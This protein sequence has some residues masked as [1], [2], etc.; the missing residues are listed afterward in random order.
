MNCEL[1]SCP[2]L[3][4]IFSHLSRRALVVHL[5]SCDSLH[6]RLVHYFTVTVMRKNFQTCWRTPTVSPGMHIIVTRSAIISDLWHSEVKEYFVSIFDLL[7]QTYLQ[8]EA[9]LLGLYRSLRAEPDSLIYS[10][11]H[12]CNFNPLNP[13]RNVYLGLFWRCLYG[14]YTVQ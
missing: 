8:H 2:F 14:W 5:N 13:G 11:K 7:G 4:F 12:F 10:R 9:A 6:L 1:D 3:A